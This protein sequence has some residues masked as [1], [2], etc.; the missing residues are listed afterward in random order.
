M[1]AFNKDCSRDDWDGAEKPA[2]LYEASC[3][4]W[5]TESGMTD[6]EKVD[7]PTFQ[8]CGGY[9]RENNWREEWRK[10]FEG[11]SGEDVQKVRDLPNFDYDV[12]EEITGLDIRPQEKPKTCD[13]KTVEIDG[14]KY[15]LREIN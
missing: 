9:L 4:T 1:R 2:W 10:A 11:A 12:F 13:G 6:A 8:T 5:V 3:T 15:E 7:N 14:V